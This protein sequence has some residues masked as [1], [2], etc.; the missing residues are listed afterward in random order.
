[1]VEFEADDAIAT[2]VKRFAPHADQVV[3]GSPDKDLCQCISGD[4]I[5][6][7]DSIRR[8]MTNENDVLAK[9]GVGPRSIPDWLALVGDSADGLP[10]VPRWGAKSAAALLSRYGHLEDIP[11]SESDWDVP[12]RG[13]AA[14]SENLRLHLDRAY[15]YRE[16]ATLRTDVP[17][18]E[19]LDELR[20]VGARREELGAICDEIG[21]ASVMDVVTRWRS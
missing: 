20:W 15:L 1:M 12:V 17:L 18:T 9:F 5:V 8:R 11:L 10:G 2:A 7:F 21:D 14:L 19:T 3:I 6:S 4:R 13:A 16:L